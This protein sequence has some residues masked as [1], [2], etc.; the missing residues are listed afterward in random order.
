MGCGEHSDSLS[1]LKSLRRPSENGLLLQLLGVGGERG[2]GE[3]KPRFNSHAED[4]LKLCF[5]QFFSYK[6]VS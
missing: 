3:K 4:A 2:T 1:P 6:C 5:Q